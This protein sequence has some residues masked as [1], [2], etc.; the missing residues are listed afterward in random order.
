MAQ[1]LFQ[2]FSN[3]E[4][5]L[6]LPPEVLAGIIIEHIPDHRRREGHFLLEDFIYGCVQQHSDHNAYPR[7]YE[8]PVINTIAEALNWLIA[9][10][11]VM[12]DPGQPSQW[13]MLTRRGQSLKTSADVEAFRKAHILPR[14]LLNPVFLERV[15]PLFLQGDYDTA[16]FRAFK[17]I[18]VR[19]REACHYSD[20]LLGVDLMRKAFH[21]DC[22]PLRNRATVTSERQAERDLFVGSIGHAK[23]PSSHRNID[24]DPGAAAQ[25]IVFA[26][27]LL[28]IV[29][30][31][32]T[33]MPTATG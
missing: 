21:E 9:Q 25:L 31:R 18:E 10:G 29:E 20:R 11:F 8:T 30:R 3:P 19:V 27:Y 17:E 7:K 33:E 2:I 6:S 22:G 5:L 13:L 4:D 1:T 26:S 24:H 12:P 15:W 14:E 32:T 16:V 28:D 23:N